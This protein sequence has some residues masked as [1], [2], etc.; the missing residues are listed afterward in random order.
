MRV[1]F[2]HNIHKCYWICSSIYSDVMRHTFK[3]SLFY[4]I[5]HWSYCVVS[6]GYVWINAIEYYRISSALAA[7]KF[8]IITDFLATYFFMALQVTSINGTIRLENAFYYY[9]H[10]Y[11][12]CIDITGTLNVGKDNMQILIIIVRWSIREYICKR[13]YSLYD[14]CKCIYVRT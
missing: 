4:C 5:P 9:C 7:S 14:T 1:N 8:K 11:P 2:I 10:T 13:W 3:M 6:I 12:Y